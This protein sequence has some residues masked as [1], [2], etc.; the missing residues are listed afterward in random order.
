MTTKHFV[1]C[2]G[3][4][5][6]GG[7]RGVALAGAYEE[8]YRNGVR[9][10]EVAGTSAG[11]II[12]ALIGA[13]ALPSDLS[14]IVGELE[15]HSFLLPPKPMGMKKEWRTFLSSLG[16][17]PIP[18]PLKTFLREGGSYSSEAIESWMNELLSKLLPDVTSN[19]CFGD[20]PIPTYVVAANLT[21]KRPK[22]WST[23]DTPE[24]S[25]AFAV[26]A[27]CSI[28][29]FFQPV[30]EGSNFYVDGG[31]LAN[32]PL[33]VFSDSGHIR[34]YQRER[35]L[36]FILASKSS[37]IDLQTVYGYLRELMNLSI[38][39]ATRLQQSVQPGVASIEIDTLG[40]NATDFEKMTEEKTLDL[41][42]SGKKAASQFFASE[43]INT[44]GNAYLGTQTWDQ[45]EAF[46]AIVERADAVHAEAVIV[47]ND[48]AWFWELFPTI[49]GWRRRGVAVHCFVTPIQ[50][51][52]QSMKNEAL[53][54]KHLAGMGVKI[55]ERATLPLRGVLVDADSDSA[56]EPY[57]V[58]L[59][60]RD[61]DYLPWASV[62]R[63][64]NDSSAIAAMY[65][66]L[67][68]EIIRTPV[69]T[70][71]CDLEE[72][73]ESSIIDL[74]RAGVSHY[75]A[76]SVSIS[77]ESIPVDSILLLSRYVRSF[78]LRQLPALTEAYRSC[79]IDLYR[80][81]NLILD[82]ATP[83]I[84]TPPVFEESGG[85]FVAI[86]GNTR[87]FWAFSQ[88][89]ATITG[90]V[91][92]NVQ[93]DLP[94]VPLPVRHVR[95]ASSKMSPNDRIEGFNHALFRDIERSTHP[96]S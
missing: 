62:Y 82:G 64:H 48:T 43:H 79:G 54:R 36:A 22:V 52:S 40:V 38:E 4:F 53:R 44:A 56:G 96:T 50:G 37:H 42:D 47:D 2:R 16:I 25:V 83:S 66:Q 9:F 17:V 34:K 20:L 71:G 49:L 28:P 27:S 11:S 88:N 68:S 73:N 70:N 19:V 24:A 46:H 63:A 86:E 33:F 61:G 5:Q 89:L 93:A 85:R 3:V 74:L 60:D 77:C 14:T 21:E 29:V 26:R 92:R 31:T 35:I 18:K 15:Y 41:L 65:H 45:H 90:I 30:T 6:G 12:A 10:S 72:V 58:V 81:V 75:R 87:S 67:A 51:A 84:V 80:P 78:R 57:A 1:S 7:C 95:I 55:I 13:G 23:K 8:A 39:G 32:L 94:G 76:S 91:V 69:S 59:A